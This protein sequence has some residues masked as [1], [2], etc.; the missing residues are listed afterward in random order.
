ML[1]RPAGRQIHPWQGSLQRILVRGRGRF[2]VV[3]PLQLCDGD[4]APEGQTGQE[5][6]TE[7]DKTDAFAEVVACITDFYT[8]E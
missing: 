2:R 3:V 4:A 7:T 5:A 8:V 1:C 6:R